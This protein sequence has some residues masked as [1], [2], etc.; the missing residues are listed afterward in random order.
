MNET[1]HGGTCQG[2]EQMDDCASVHAVGPA[3]MILI[4]AFTDDLLIIQRFVPE[5]VNGM[6]QLKLSD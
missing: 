4:D 6:F 3:V 2:D 1:Q 5:K